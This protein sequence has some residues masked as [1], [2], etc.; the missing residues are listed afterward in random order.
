[1]NGLIRFSLGNRRAITVFVL[2]IILL[3]GIALATIPADILPVYRSPAVQVLTFYNGMPATS[4]EADITTRMERWCGQTAG[5]VRQESRSII[6]ASIV[7]NYFADDV[8]PNGALAQVNSLATGAVAYLPPGT[9]PPIILPYDPTASTPVALVA[10]NSRSQSEAKLYD[11]GR[12]EVRNMI[13]A[14]RGAN[15]PVVYGGRLRTVLA[16]L[17][18]DELQV[19]NLSAVDVMNAIDRYNIFLP[20]GDVKIGDTDYALDSNSMYK[21]IRRMKEIPI[22]IDADGKMV[23]LDDVADIR[24]DSLPQTNIVR[25]DGRRQVYIPVY[26]QQGA[27]TLTVV[28]HLRDGLPDMK[29]RVTTPDVDLKLVMDQS[30]YVRKAIESLAEEGVL[31]AI[32]C[33]LV[34]LV[35][36]GEWRMTLI[37]VMT[38]PIA[39]LGAIAG[40]SATGQ[41]INVMTLAGLA[42]A[43]GPLVDSAI[44][45]LENTHRHLGLG[46]KPRE[47]A[48]LGASE[49]AMPELVA[50]LCTLLVLAP[51]AFM[52]GMGKFLFRPMFLAVAFAMGIAY[53]LSRTFVPSRCANWLPHRKHEPIESH[54]F[55][56]EHRN[57]HENP[58]SQRKFGR[59]FERWEGLIDRGIK[60]YVRLLE[61]VLKARALVVAIA[62]GLLAVVLIGIGPQLR[63]EF[64]P[65]VDAGSF[66]IYVR[67]KS[68]TRI[69]LTE[70]KIEKVENYVR[71]RLGDDLDIFIS[72]IGLT[73]DWS[74]AFT[75]NAGPMD[76]V[77]KVQ[78]KANRGRSAQECVDLLRQGFR[79][80][81]EFLRE[82]I[83]L[84]SDLEPG[85]DPVGLEFAF[86]AGGM[87]RA[88]M[89]E[90]K[91]SPITIRITAKDTSHSDAEDPPDVS[92]ALVKARKIAEKMLEEVKRIDGVV[93]A[94]IL[95]RLDYP[96]YKIEIDQAAAAKLQLTQEDVMKNVI[97][98]LN[99]SVQFNKR[100]FWIDP[101]SHNQ[102][103]VGVQYPEKKIE[104]LETLKDIPITSTT[105]NK[106]V[107][108]RNLISAIHYVDVPA[109]VAHTNL[110][111]TMEL[112]MGVHGRDLGH[113]ANDVEKVV[114]KYGAARDDGGWTPFDPDLQGDQPM[115]GAKIVMSG[116]YQKMEQTFRSQALGMI[117]AVVLI[118][119]LMVALFKSYITPLV[120]MC[121]VP[122][123]VVGVVFV[124][125]VTGTALNVQSLL[126]VIFMVG[127]VVSNTVLLTDFAQHL[128]RTEGLSPTEAIR[129]AAAIRARPVVMTAL[130]TFFALVPMALG[131]SRG[132]E[133]N[134]P[135]GRAV[136]G[137]L[138]AG[139]VTTLLVVPCVFSL[140]VRGEIEDET[141]EDVVPVTPAQNGD[142]APGNQ[143]SAPEAK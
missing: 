124:L 101:R 26:R 116:E 5:T 96:L 100:N 36:L 76:A 25:V 42:L 31:G 80:D 17:N 113:V 81:P 70:K 143:S 72:E 71:K 91:S 60:A 93:D 67:A 64:F 33:S 73:S 130:A 2:T 98:S 61:S 118:Y 83:S 114:A 45:C 133:A 123:G 12:Y 69:E 34:I 11:C 132:S 139:L 38:I 129:R 119:F 128:R 24:D 74:S 88:A 19:R 77:V 65:E 135:L 51:L 18:R 15:A 10:L 126:G 99:S 41:T 62:F 20:A 53:I 90:G 105:Q 4:V 22:K 9:L 16:F 106:S 47:A 44:I 14:S 111:P 6:G 21:L 29:E 58:P 141:A 140:F 1:M 40:L 50:S 78:L 66:E 120:V 112:T 107:P 142:E 79:S 23:Y 75:P 39:V 108:L 87:I 125:F 13:M 109:E 68:G 59:L 37:A 115:E 127:I 35:F 131:L 92:P 137:G 94:R 48:F 43:I 52:P 49:V 28:D 103:Y 46:A 7:R 136:L 3:G 121:A 138:L 32:L 57:P 63:R 56:Y 85:E 89:N 54:T 97:A 102:Y 82:F 84:S 55:D 27:S 134:V 104:S 86:D 95:Q 110:Q 30:I 117:L 122:I 8:D